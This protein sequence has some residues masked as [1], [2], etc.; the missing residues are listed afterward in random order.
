MNRKDYKIHIIGGG[1]S[2]LIAAK[3]L[4]ENGFKP[5]VI[6][7]TDRAGGRIKT[8]IIEGYQLDH[9]FQV[10]LTAYPAVKKYLDCKALDLQNFLP[11]AS[12]FKANKQSIIGDPLRD[13]SLLISTLFSE[14]GTIS[15][16]I[17]ILKLNH[18]IKKKSL[19]DIFSEKEQTTISYLRE[20]GFSKEIL[21]DFFIPFFS[22]IFLENKLETSSRMFEFV[23]K[24]FGEGHAAIPKAGMEAIP[25]QLLNNLKTTTFQYNTKVTSVEEGEIT[26][27]NGSKLVSDFTILTIPADSLLSSLKK[28]SIKWRSCITLY[29]ET[30]I[31]VINRPLIGLIAKQNSL[32]NNIVYNS[33]LCSTTKPENELLC[34]TVIDD[35]GLT[36]LELVKAVKKE[37]K[38]ICNITVFRLI[39]QYQITKA[40]PILKNLKYEMKPSET[41]LSKSL[42]IAGDTQLNASFN[43]AMISGELAALELIKAATNRI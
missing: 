18:E 2:G 3:V 34:V 40:L 41:R 19:T 38:I 35:Q 12:I 9:G 17:K 42:F 22:G 26:L 36:N 8:D 32:V 15:D 27:K 7:A 33:S 39:K 1:V 11:G 30:K 4:E 14:I 43:A 5:T 20:L 25:K 6:E 31:K 10:I 29:F 37:L 23:Y 13:V 16:K 24:M 28:N 21:N